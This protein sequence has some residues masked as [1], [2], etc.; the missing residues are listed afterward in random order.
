ML[1]YQRVDHLR[2]VPEFWGLSSTT[3][4]SLEAQSPRGQHCQILH[5]S[6]LLL[7]IELR[8]RI[9][10]GGPR[11]MVPVSLVLFI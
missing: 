10:T 6:Q 7:T 8:L 1:V 11:P 9:G 2:T 4:P 3:L 5:C